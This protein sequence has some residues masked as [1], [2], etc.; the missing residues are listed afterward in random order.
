[1]PKVFADY[2]SQGHNWITLATGEYYPDILKDACE[3]YKPVLVLFGQLLKTSE[4]SER[5]LIQISEIPSQWMQIQL[6]RVFPKYVS[7]PIPVEM[8]KRK[9]KTEVK[10]ENLKRLF[11]WS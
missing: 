9:T 3:L 5:L 11:K 1:M 8:L 7:P 10:K 6:A 2:K 4:S